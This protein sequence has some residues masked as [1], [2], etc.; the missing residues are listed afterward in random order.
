MDIEVRMRHVDEWTLTK[1]SLDVDRQCNRMPCRILQNLEIIIE[2]KICTQRKFRK[3]NNASS[4]H[5][6][7]R[8]DGGCI[9]LNPY[10]KNYCSN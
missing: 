1:H 6:G 7:G 10:L 3:R 9:G 8:G 2:A 5:R 4:D